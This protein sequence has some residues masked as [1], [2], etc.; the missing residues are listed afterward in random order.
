[1]ISTVLR[2]NDKGSAAIR[3]LPLLRTNIDVNHL[4]DYQSVISNNGKQTFKWKAMFYGN[5]HKAYVDGKLCQVKKETD[6]LGNTISYVITT[7]R[8]GMKENVRVDK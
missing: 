3:H 2:M 6:V 7:V 4:D 1:M 8:P 5:Y